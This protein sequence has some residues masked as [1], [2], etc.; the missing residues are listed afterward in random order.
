[1]SKTKITVLCTVIMAIVVLL[2]AM[3]VVVPLFKFDVVP[4]FKF[5]TH[6][7]VTYPSEVI[8]GDPVSIYAELKNNGLIAR[9]YGVPL[10]INGAIIE[11]KSITIAAGSQESVSFEY[12]PDSSGTYTVTLGTASTT[13][14]S[15]EGFLPTWYNGDTWTYQ[16]T[17]PSGISEITYENMGEGV[18]ENTSVYLLRQSSSAL[19]QSF[20]VGSSFIDT[21]TLVTVEQ[22]QSH[23]ENG[24]PFFQ[25]TVFNS[26]ITDGERWPLIL[27]TGWTVHY[28]TLTI[29][30]RGLLVTSTQEELVHTYSVEKR[31]L[32]TTPA[33]TFR[34]L[35]IVER[36]AQ[37][38][39]VGTFWYSDKVKREVKYELTV[40]GAIHSYELQSYR[41]QTEPPPTPY[42]KLTIKSSVLYEDPTN[43]YMVYYPSNWQLITKQETGATHLMTTEG[44]HQLPVGSIDIRTRVV[45]A[46]GDTSL[47]T[48]CEDIV[49]TTRDNDSNFIL[50][51]TIKIPATVPWY[52]LTWHSKFNDIS[53]KGK[54]LVALQGE[55]L[56][57]VTGWV[58]EE[59]ETT[60]YPQLQ[61]IISSFGIITQPLP[62]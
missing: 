42:P 17:T 9:E 21:R 7:L 40:D 60:Y 12:I 1:M 58:Q 52:E 16:V 56:Y 49:A 27:G 18:Y 57:I 4:L 28:N 51:G 22:E 8:A 34:C 5:E 39:L 29:A 36:D 48:Y 30:K 20:F 37:N 59:F 43:K 19:S 6:N 25:K 32:I 13:F 2:V 45:T 35:K 24:I 11:T 3:F 61:Q 15:K 55:Q 44:A 62:R 41:I 26:T 14:T 47:D 33:G 54:T 46:S 50:D 31:E 10:K 23:L 38:N 53:T